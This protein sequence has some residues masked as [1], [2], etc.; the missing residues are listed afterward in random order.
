V[1]REKADAIAHEA[2]DPASPFYTATSAD[3]W[4]DF[5]GAL[6]DCGAK[7]CHVT[8]APDLPDPLRSLAGK[9]GAK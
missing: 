4:K 2:S 9:R 1:I 5:A 7:N 3:N 6:Q 8:F